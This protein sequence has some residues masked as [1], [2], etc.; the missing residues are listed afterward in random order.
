MMKTYMKFLFY[1]KTIK[2]IM[3]IARYFLISHKIYTFQNF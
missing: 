3:L 2:A 1:I